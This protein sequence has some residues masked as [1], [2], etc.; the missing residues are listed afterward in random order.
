MN[1]C[2]T[3]MGFTLIEL[4]VVI[5]ILGV[6]AALLFPVFLKARENA[7][8]TV[9]VSN[10]RQIG[11]ALQMYQADDSGVLPPM[12]G[13]ASSIPVNERT[14]LD[15]LQPYEHD[16]ALYHCP[17]RRGPIPES[18]FLREDYQYRVQ[19]LLQIQDK[20]GQPEAIVRPAPLS[21]LLYD[22]HHTQG[23]DT[24]YSILRANGSVSYVPLSRAVSWSYLPGGRWVQG[25][26]DPEMEVFPDEPWPPQFE[27]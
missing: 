11:L 1:A 6:L 16:P 12:F 13:D 27:K 14:G 26:G 22:W 10:L 8:K 2:R 25:A 7:N 5:T 23:R 3:R 20:D 19:D 15:T 9:C 24:T 18:H 21:V 17:D 4:L